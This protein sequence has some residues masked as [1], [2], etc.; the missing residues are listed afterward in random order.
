MNDRIHNLLL[1]ERSFDKLFCDV[2]NTE[3]FDIYYNETFSEDPVFNH[4]VIDDS[5]MDSSIGMDDDD[6]SLALLLHEIKS[7][8]ESRNILP[9]IFVEREWSCARKIEEVAVQDGY[10]ISGMMEILF[11]EDT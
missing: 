10:H 4:V 8:T 6:D 5:I 2:A 1:N 3:R 9:T 7:E 11:K